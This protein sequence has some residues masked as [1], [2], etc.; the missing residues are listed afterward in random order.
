MSS[1]GMSLGMCKSWNS[2]D[3]NLD[4]NCE[5]FQQRSTLEPVVITALL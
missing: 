5:V 3:F 4:S 2:T 1:Y